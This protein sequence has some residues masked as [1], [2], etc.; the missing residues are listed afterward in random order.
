MPTPPIARICERRARATQNT[1]EGT[2]G[3]VDGTAGPQQGADPVLH[4][5]PEGA[6]ADGISAGQQCGR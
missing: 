6:R 5:N 2:G 3:Q 4:R 1:T